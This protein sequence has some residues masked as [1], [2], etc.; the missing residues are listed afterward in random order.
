MTKFKVGDI[1]VDRVSVE[2]IVSINSVQIETV[3]LLTNTNYYYNTK[4]CITGFSQYYI[5]PYTNIY[6]YLYINQPTKDPFI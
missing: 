3:S 1:V 2:R 6:K 5:I 4:G